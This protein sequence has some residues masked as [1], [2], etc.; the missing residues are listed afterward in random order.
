VAIDPLDSRIY[1]VAGGEDHCIWKLEVLDGIGHDVRVTVF[2]GDPAHSPGFVDAAG[3]SAR[4]NVPFSLA[5][6]PVA[7]VLYVSDQENDAIRRITRAGV[8]TTVAGSPGMEARLMAAGALDV[9]N[10]TNNRVLS[11]FEVTLAQAGTGVRPDIYKPQ[12]VRVDSQG[13][14]VFVE[15]GFGA[16][17]RLHPATFVTTRLA[18]VRQRFNA[19]DR[20]WVWLDVD[21]GGKVGPVDGT[22]WCA[23]TLEF[24]EGEAT[25][26]FNEVYAWIPPEGG[27]SRFIFAQ[28]SLNDLWPDGWGPRDQCNPPHYPWLIAI[29]PRGAVWLAGLGEHGICRLRKQRAGDPGVRPFDEQFDGYYNRGQLAFTFGVEARTTNIASPSL[30]AKFGF[31]AH[32]YLGTRDAYEFTTNTASATVLDAFEAPPHLRT[33]ATVGPDFLDYLRRQMAPATRGG[34]GGW[35]FMHFGSETNAGPAADTADPDGDGVPNLFEH[36]FGTNPNVSD[37]PPL[38]GRVESVAGTNYLTVECRTAALPFWDVALDAQVSTNLVTW[39]S[40]RLL[41]GYPLANGDGTLTWKWR[42]VTP[43]PAGARGFLRLRAQPR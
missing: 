38:T 37:R 29:D 16:I 2:A 18:D 15:L 31:D 42:D 19:D 13:R 14:L 30:A 43:Q 25:G 4:F 3:H 11:R 39:S 34:R 17:R 28:S 33:N 23:S 7:D 32:N 41:P 26:R 20:G 10:Q 5:W 6:D 8:V 35:R 1:Y 21:R 27:G 22:Y 40:A 12:T 24:V 9:F 36:L